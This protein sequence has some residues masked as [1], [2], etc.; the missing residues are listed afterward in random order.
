MAS[1]W[2][3]ID[4]DGTV[5][6]RTAD[7]ERAIGS[8]Q[9]GDREAGL[10]FYVR[11]FEDLETEVQLLEK[12]LESG[13][14][15]PAH[16]R[17]TAS[18]L[19]EQIA[20]AA[21]IGDLASLEQRLNALLAAADEKAG[22]AAAAREQARADAIAAKEALVAE[23]EKIAESA[24]SWKASGDRLRAIVDEWRQI[25]GIDRRTDDALWKRF[26]AA[27][28]AFS[29]RRGQHFAQLDAERSTVKQVKE[30]LI[31]RAEELSTSTDWKETT[32][33]MR[34]LMTEWKAAGRA[35]RD[36]EDALW[37]R[38]RAAQ[39]AF[40]AR[41]S[42]TF[43]ER[44]AE[45]L[46][47]Q[48]AKEAIIAKAAALDVSDPKAAQSAL[49]ELQAQFDEIGHV[50]RDAM[51]RLDDQMRAAE[52]RVRDAVDAE[53]RQ[54]SAESNPFLAALRERLAE[55]EAKLE[56]ARKS[57]D[58]ARIKKAEDEVAQRRALLPE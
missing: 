34:E 14:G 17:A 26:A 52:Q 19:K 28:D 18:A 10:A 12:R 50:P 48:R 47:N 20:S 1:D 44:D 11:R 6:V 51:R 22:E 7:G 8:W 5:Y 4:D 55:A 39:D 23:A 43:A 40:F 25:K 9:A 35:G 36:V 38:F 13:A 45:Q 33:A 42:E 57:G 27:R 46:G 53:W 49:R 24:T 54:G 56:R 31:A 58:A 32:A 37:A 16:T 30:R 3:R 29:R 41:R 21:A 15:D 2:G